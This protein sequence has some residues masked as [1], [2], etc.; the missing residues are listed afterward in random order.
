MYILINIFQHLVMFSK[1]EFN[2]FKK[3]FI[4]I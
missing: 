1:A 2:T 4:A 3:I